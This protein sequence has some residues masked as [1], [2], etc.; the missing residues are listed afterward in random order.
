MPCSY[1]L[2]R[3]QSNAPAI[4]LLT[5]VSQSVVLYICF[6]MEV[7]LTETDEVSQNVLTIQLV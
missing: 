5:L 1:S 6:T 4:E 2:Q 7:K 3:V